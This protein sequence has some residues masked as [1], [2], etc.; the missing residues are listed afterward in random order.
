MKKS[1]GILILLV[2]ALLLGGLSYVAVQGV[3]AEKTGSASSIKLGLDLAGG[4]SITY[5]VVGEEKPDS[6]DMEDTIY[7]L[8]QRVE[9]YSTEA[10]VYQEGNDRINRNSRCQRCQYYSGGIGKAGFFVLYCTE[11]QRGEFEL[12]ILFNGKRGR[13]LL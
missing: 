3:G 4:V 2:M 8:Q 5:R 9:G 6:E 12:Y 1:R 11:R 13:N 10:V 7:K